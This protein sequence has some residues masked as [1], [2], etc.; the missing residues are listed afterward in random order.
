V[1]VHRTVAGKH[2]IPVGE[3]TVLCGVPTKTYT[4]IASSE[5]ALCIVRTA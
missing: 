5:H 1:G 4:V 2:G 3:H